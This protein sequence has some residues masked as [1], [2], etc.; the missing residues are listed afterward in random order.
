MSINNITLTTNGS[1]ALSMTGAGTKSVG[2]YNCYV[3]CTN[4]TGINISGAGTNSLYLASSGADVT[5]TAIT[6]FAAS[7]AGLVSI[8]NSNFNNTGNS[9]LASSFAST[10]GLLLNFSTFPYPIS[11]TGTGNAVLYN[12]SITTQAINQ[13]AITISGTSSSNSIRHC[14]IQSGTAIPISVG[15]G[16][17]VDIEMLS[18]FTTNSTATTGLGTINYSL[19]SAFGNA[20]AT[21]LSLGTSVNNVTASRLMVYGM[22]VTPPAATIGEQIRGNANAVLGVSVLSNLVTISLTAGVWDVTGV[23]NFIFSAAAA[24]CQLGV[25]A[26]SATLSGT[27]GD[28]WLQVYPGTPV[29]V[30]S[31]IIIVVPA[32]RVVL[33]TTTSYYLVVLASSGSPTCRGRLSA[34]RVG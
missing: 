34:T 15:T 1:F 24:Y 33:T 10:M 30:A 32:F 18:L 2:L 7:S 14:Q 19:I 26:T 5:T 11:N 17:T 3:N 28:Q 4:S 8:T 6:L 9:L 12:S 21:T 22:T 25:S 23:G 31:N 16:C 13:T 29:P 20:S 27:Q